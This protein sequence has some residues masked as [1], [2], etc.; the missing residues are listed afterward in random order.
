MVMVEFR[1]NC[2]RDHLPDSW[3]LMLLANFDDTAHLTRAIDLPEEKLANANSSAR[4]GSLGI[5]ITY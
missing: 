5:S 4:L 1:V 2:E 3:Y